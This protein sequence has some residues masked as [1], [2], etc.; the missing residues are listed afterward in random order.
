MD[1]THRE[2]T[3]EMKDEKEIKKADKAQKVRCQTVNNNQEGADDRR[4]EKETKEDA[5]YSWVNVD[6]ETSET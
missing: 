2:W 4:R 3:H 1:K 5:T 6:L